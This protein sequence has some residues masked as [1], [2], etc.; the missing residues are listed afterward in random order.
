MLVRRILVTDIPTSRADSDVVVWLGAGAA[1]AGLAA[2]ALVIEASSPHAAAVFVAAE[3]AVLRL[4][5][6]R[7]LEFLSL[8]AD[9][10]RAPALRAA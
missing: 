7:P 5:L 10:S 8:L 3:P 2:D 6:A 1:P 9:V 4:S